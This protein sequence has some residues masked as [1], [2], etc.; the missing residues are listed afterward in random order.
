LIP[1]R[2]SPSSVS[3]RTLLIASDRPAGNCEILFLKVFAIYV[4]APAPFD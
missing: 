4:A 2:V 3:A 1:L